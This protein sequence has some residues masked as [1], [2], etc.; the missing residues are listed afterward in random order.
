MEAN[1]NHK[2][3]QLLSETAEMSDMETAILG[4]TTDTQ[5]PDNRSDSLMYLYLSV[6]LSLSL[7]G[8]M[9]KEI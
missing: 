6:V 3:L 7:C 8:A 2:D 5:T 1:K 4:A 9:K